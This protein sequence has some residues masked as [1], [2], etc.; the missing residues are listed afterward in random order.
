MIKNFSINNMGM[1]LMSG[2]NE[3][4]VMT[5]DNVVQIIDVPLYNKVLRT[6]E[7]SNPM[8]E[9]FNFDTYKNYD[10]DA[11][12]PILFDR[13]EKNL[14]KWALKP[15]FKEK[16]DC[17]LLYNSLLSQYGKEVYNNAEFSETA[18][19]IPIILQQKNLS[20]IH[21]VMDEV[22]SKI[23][24][25]RLVDLLGPYAYRIQVHILDEPLI[26][27]ILRELNDFTLLFHDDACIIP[28]LKEKG[29]D[30]SEKCFAISNLS[31]NFCYDEVTELITAR[32]DVFGLIEEHGVGIGYVDLKRFSDDKYFRRG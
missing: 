20:K 1:D 15:E 23:K 13:I 11:I 24:I 17:E 27:Y 12:Q 31:Y 8:Y 22:N 21:I 26:E 18:S 14:I 2:R 6:L 32:I 28:E 7:P 5:Y 4:I 25:Q 29:L 9:L 19:N 10:D 3:K 16:Y 30:I